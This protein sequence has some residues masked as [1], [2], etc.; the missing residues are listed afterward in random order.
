MI[1]PG[2]LTGIEMRGPDFR[3]FSPGGDKSLFRLPAGPASGMPVSR[4]VA[5]EAPIDALS[6]AAIEGS[7]GDSLYVAT[8]GGMGPETIRALE[9]KLHEIAV[10]P[11]AVLVAATD[12]D[13]AGDAYADRLQQM[14]VSAGTRF[15]RLRPA[16]KDWNE[17]LQQ[18]R[19]A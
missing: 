18:G 11:G 9:L 10:L 17:A 12:A 3:G 6:L 1:T 19:G 13:R 16:V 15:E 8:A 4:L 5:A 2:R 14:A 7:R